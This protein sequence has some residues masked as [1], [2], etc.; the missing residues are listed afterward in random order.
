MVI[1]NNLIIQFGTNIFPGNVDAIV[2][3]TFPI[4]FTH[5]YS[6]VPAIRAINRTTIYNT[7]PYVNNLTLTNFKTFS[8]QGPTYGTFWMAVG[9]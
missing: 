1:N 4:S 9:N 8:T 6:V 7:A 3:I 2:V 5:V